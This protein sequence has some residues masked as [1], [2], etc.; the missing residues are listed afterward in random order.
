VTTG[1][2]RSSSKRPAGPR[3]PFSQ[4]LLKTG[5]VFL[6]SALALNALVGARGL[7]AVLQAK[8]DY[9]R[10]AEELN[11]VRQENAQLRTEV[12]RLKE[13]PAAIEELARGELNFIHPGEVVFIIHDVQPNARR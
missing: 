1:P 13:D 10:A 2:A 3:V 5:L 6:M 9:Q 12:R 8:K 4:R 7:P 11:R